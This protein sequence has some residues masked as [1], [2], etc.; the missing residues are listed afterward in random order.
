MTA[1][2]RTLPWRL[3]FSYYKIDVEQQNPT[4]QIDPTC[5]E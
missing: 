5:G 3:R 1:C 4:G 2:T